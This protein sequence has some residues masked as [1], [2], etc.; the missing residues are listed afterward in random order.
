MFQKIKM[1]LIKGLGVSL[2]TFLLL[3]YQNCAKP[4]DD[5]SLSSSSLGTAAC[6]L[7]L[8]TT[9]IVAGFPLKITYSY[10]PAADKIQ[11]VVSNDATGVST[12]NLFSGNGS[13]TVTNSVAGA[14]TVSGIVQNSSGTTDGICQKK[15]TVKTVVALPEEPSPPSVPTITLS[16]DKT[17]C[18]GSCTFNLTHNSSD[19]GGSGHVFRIVKLNGTTAKDIACK[20]VNGIVTTQVS[21]SY[22]T[23]PGL[24]SF[25]AYFVSTCTSPTAGLQAAATLNM[26]VNQ[27]PPT[28]TYAWQIGAYGLCSAVA[29]DSE[30]TQTRTVICKRNDGLTVTDSFCGTKP[31]TTQICYGKPCPDPCKTTGFCP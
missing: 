4:L 2:I 1:P 8:S 6:S 11:I 13:T 19:I 25:I 14:Y 16:G 23:D 29:C 3:S 21:L 22:A 18:T 9:S 12:Q 5:I 26:T 28:Y 7:T 20:S 31:A 27:A 17:T 30:G 10:T 24:N 15:F